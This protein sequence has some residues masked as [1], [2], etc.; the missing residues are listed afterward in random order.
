MWLSNFIEI[1]P[2][3]A[4]NYTRCV[5]Q[6]YRRA[7]FILLEAPLSAPADSERFGI[8]MRRPPRNRVGPQIDIRTIDAQ[9]RDASIGGGINEKT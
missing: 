4:R 8:D 7:I 5:K 9:G 3:R 6:T 2:L 1:E